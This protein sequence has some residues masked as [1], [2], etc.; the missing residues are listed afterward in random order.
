[1]SSVTPVSP[2]DQ[3]SAAAVFLRIFWMILGNMVLGLS[4]LVIAGGASTPGAADAVFCG[5]VPLLIA[6]RRVDILRHGGKTASGEPATM[7]HWRRHAILLLAC[8]AVLWAAARGA[9]YLM[10]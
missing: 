6:A 2:H 1:M 10:N 3:T 5:T 7:S 4:A 8:A 9:A